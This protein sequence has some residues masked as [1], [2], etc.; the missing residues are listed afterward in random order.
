[1]GTT[2]IFV[3]SLPEGTSSNDIRALFEAYGA[4]AECDVIKDYGFVHMMNDAD[5]QA[6]IEALNGHEFRGVAILVEE[7]RSRVR[8]QPGM[9]GRMT[10]FRCGRQGHWSKECRAGGV[11][12]DGSTA[13]REYRPGPYSRPPGYDRR[14]PPLR[15]GPAS[16]SYAGS[17]YERYE[18]HE[19]AGSGTSGYDR[20]RYERL[21][22]SAY[23]SRGGG[24]SES[25][26]ERASPYEDT[27]EYRRALRSIYER[28]SDDYGYEPRGSKEYGSSRRA[29]YFD[30]RSPSKI[31]YSRRDSWT[32]GGGNRGGSG[33]DREIRRGYE[34]SRKSSSAYE[35]SQSVRQYTPRDRYY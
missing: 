31:K 35:S 26:Y 33:S 11:G 18:R 15:G 24:Y 29:E 12:S 32:N 8:H 1:M 2:K 10:C 19:R 22:S 13:Y 9:G 6:A 20:D 4:V 21:S 16:S 27:S 17:P 30:R 23:D 7:S 28:R 34:S 25:R 14:G 5:A 3:G